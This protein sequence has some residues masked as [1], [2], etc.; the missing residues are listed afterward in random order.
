M[1]PEAS[2]TIEQQGPAAAVVIV[3]NNQRD[4]LVRC[5]RSLEASTIR[6]RMEII[7]VDSGS[8][9]GSGRVDEE[10][11]QITVLR[12]PR[13]FGKSRARNIGVRTAK[14]D[15]LLFTDPRVEF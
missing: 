15:L 12:L 5:L 14:A 2:E 13:D 11:E 3:V 7:V 10:F 4:A 8:G 9:D 1:Q 6:Q